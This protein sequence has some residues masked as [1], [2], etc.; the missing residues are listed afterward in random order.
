MSTVEI[1]K[2][3]AEGSPRARNRFVLAYY[4]VSILTGMVFFFMHGRF[5]FAANLVAAVFYL[6]ATAAFYESSVGKR[7]DRR[8]QRR[9]P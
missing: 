7:A 6:L 3:M 1:T 2:P 9:A 5:A 8:H 4:L